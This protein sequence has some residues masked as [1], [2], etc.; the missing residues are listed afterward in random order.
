[1]GLLSTLLLLDSIDKLIMPSRKH[2]TKYQV[3]DKPFTSDDPLEIKEAKEIANKVKFTTCFFLH[4]M[5]ADDNKLSRNEKKEIKNISIE[6]EGYLD[7]SD[8]QEIQDILS[9]KPSMK[10]VVKT[11]VTYDISSDY[12]QKAISFFR[13]VTERDPR[14]DY[15]LQRLERELVIASEYLK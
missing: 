4:L 8:R 15:V 14:Y 7:I 1:M 6:K 9:S 10:D 13:I 5:Y 2:R 3:E 12:V 11:A